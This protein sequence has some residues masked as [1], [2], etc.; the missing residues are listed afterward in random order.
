VK[1]REEMTMKST[2]DR[3]L[4]AM[5]IAERARHLRAAYDFGPTAAAMLSAHDVARELAGGEPTE[6][7]RV[8]AT[9]KLRRLGVDIPRH[10]DP[11]A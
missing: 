3:D 7:W 5:L 9:A 2:A 4:I 10:L 6:E 11:A 8:G 1:D